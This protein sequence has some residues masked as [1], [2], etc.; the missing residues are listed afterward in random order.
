MPVLNAIWCVASWISTAA[1]QRQLAELPLPAHVV[2]R[3]PVRAGIVVSLHAG[4]HP[5]VGR[6]KA[7]EL[8]AI[9][10]H[11]AHQRERRRRPG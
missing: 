9:H 3:D 2:H 6:R 10:A 1:F 8:A 11:D 5:D 4:R 7:I